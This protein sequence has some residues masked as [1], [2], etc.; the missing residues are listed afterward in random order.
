MGRLTIEQIIEHCEKITKQYEEKV[1][2]LFPVERIQSKTYWEHK[3]VA[4]YLKELQRYKDLE[5]QGRLIT[6]PCAVGDTVYVFGKFHH[7]IE[8]EKVKELR[9]TEDCIRVMADPWDGE[10]CEAHQ[11]GKT[12]K[13]DYETNGYYLSITEA[14]E[15]KQAWEE[16][17]LKEL[18]DD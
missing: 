6:L 18:E 13:S 16:A 10:I 9:I 8:E 3:Q 15:A 4:E 11:I 14:A 17:K 2:D 1:S 5:E 12:V 7:G